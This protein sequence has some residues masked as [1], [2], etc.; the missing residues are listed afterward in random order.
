MRASG[1][2]GGSG[3]CAR[4]HMLL[5]L[6]FMASFSLYYL[7]DTQCEPLPTKHFTQLGRAVLQPVLSGCDVCFCLF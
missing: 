4:E 1:K 3:D 5:E 6:C 2:E 7:Y